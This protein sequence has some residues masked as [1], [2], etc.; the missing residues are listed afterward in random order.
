MQ[1]QR[2]KSFECIRIMVFNMVRP[3][4]RPKPKEGLRTYLQFSN[5]C[6]VKISFWGFLG[7][8]ERIT[9]GI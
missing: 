5:T 4:A 1:K 3:L 8:S 7:W 2:N 6:S 9:D